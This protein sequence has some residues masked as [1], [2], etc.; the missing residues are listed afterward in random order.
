M[1]NKFTRER[2]N[3]LSRKDKKRSKKAVK[4]RERQASK[5]YVKGEV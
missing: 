5:K 2:T 1:Q 3:S 4:A